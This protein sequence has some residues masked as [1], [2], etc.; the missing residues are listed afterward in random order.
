MT[1]FPPWGGVRPPDEY[2]FSPIGGKNL[3]LHNRK[4]GNHGRNEN[5]DVAYICQGSHSYPVVVV[6][7]IL[8]LFSS[9][10][11]IVEQF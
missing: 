3:G 8:G 11:S 4:K 2:P 7:Q 9:E 10:E 6:P 5:K 1:I